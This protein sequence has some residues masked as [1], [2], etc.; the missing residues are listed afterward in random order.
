MNIEILPRLLSG[1]LFL[2]L[3]SVNA[4]AGFNVL[5]HEKS[6]V[7][8]VTRTAGG[9]G[10]GSGSILNGEGYISTNQHVIDGGRAFFV[11]LTN[12][13]DKIPA[14]VVWSSADLDLAVL[15]IPPVQSPSVKL[16][17]GVAEKGSQVFAL[18][19]PGASD[20]TTGGFATD[21][22]V[23]Q[24]IVSRAFTGPWG[25]TRSRSAQVGIIQHTAAINAG[26]SGGPLFDICGRVVGVNTAGLKKATGILLA[27][28]ISELI[29][30][31]ESQGIAYQ[32]ED[33]PCVSTEDANLRAAEEAGR[34]AAKQT[35]DKARKDMEQTAEEARKNME[36]AAEGARKSVEQ[37]KKEAEKSIDGIKKFESTS[38]LWRIFLGLGVV[39]ALIL[40]LRKPRERIVKVVESAVEPLSQRIRGIS[41]AQRRDSGGLLLS[42][43]DDRNQ[44]VQIKIGDAELKGNRKGIS[45]GRHPDIVD[46]VITSREISRR[47]ARIRF[48]A[49]GYELEDLNSSNSTWLNGRRLSPFTPTGLSPGDEIRLG[50]LTLSV[51][52]L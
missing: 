7:R 31:L 39:A 48:S 21:V 11:L 45:I 16:I 52:K 23:T 27:S 32:K 15:K 29:S 10:T 46:R 22:T 2:A 34:D 33:S 9:W 6:V 50:T 41:R 17:G 19:Y 20:Y 12:T 26:N 37:A 28:Q 4:H 42:G 1:W 14:K 3:I 38:W 51:R 47:H 8:V 49:H 44:A 40:S 36:Q 30:V 43:Y 5:E 24:G 13:S 18:G 35:A 25:N